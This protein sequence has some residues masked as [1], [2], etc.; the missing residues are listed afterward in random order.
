MMLTTLIL[1]SL[2]GT[3]SAVAPPAPIERNLLPRQT[4]LPDLSNNSQTAL[5]SAYGSAPSPPPAI[6]S[7]ARDADACSLRLPSSLS[8][9]Y[10][11]Y[12]SKV[13]SWYSANEDDISSALS[14][15]PE[16]SSFAGMLPVC[17]TALAG[18][19]NTSGGSTATQTTGS[20]ASAGGTTSTSSGEA[21][22]RETGRTFAAVAAL[23][24]AIA[25]L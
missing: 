2:T 9:N 18:Q 17:S 13:L 20:G 22:P 1:A 14:K 8:S 16:L 24:F 7:A 5:Q 4:S 15:C 23:G 3:I 12:T 10:S 11:S 21:A 25:A 19:D 6:E